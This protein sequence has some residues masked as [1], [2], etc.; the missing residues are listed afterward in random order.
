MCLCTAA[1]QQDLFRLMFFDR[2]REYHERCHANAAGDEYIAFGLGVPID[3]KRA[4]RTIHK[5]SLTF[6]KVFNP[7]CEIP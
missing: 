2:I 7:G 4:E 3:T 5:N 1:I 6:N